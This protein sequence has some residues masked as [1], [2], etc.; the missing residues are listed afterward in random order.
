MPGMKIHCSDCLELMGEEFP[1]VHR[2]LDQ[3]AKDLPTPIF[4]DYHRSL[5]HNSYGLAIIRARW[6]EKAYEAGRIHLA[7]DYDDCCL[8]NRLRDR[9]AAAVMWFNNIENMEMML[10]PSYMAAWEES[11]MAMLEDKDEDI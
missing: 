3:Y 7:R 1:E 5:L 4:F 8:I 2:W 10:I 6:G 11:L 9:V